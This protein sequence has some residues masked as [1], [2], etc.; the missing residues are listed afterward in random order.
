LG[1]LGIVICIAALII[2]WITSARLHRVSEMLFVK[3]DQA[4]DA[5]RDRISHT[6][7]RVAT[8]TSTTDEITSALRD[9]AQREAG[10]HL[11]VRLRAAE[12]SEMLAA[13]L[14]Q[15]DDWLEVAESSARH[16]QGLLSIDAAAGAP[17]DETLVDQLISTLASMRTQLA[18]AIEAADSLRDRVTD[19]SGG[20]SLDQRI[21]QA[22]P[23]ALRVVTT[24][25][26]IEARLEKLTDGISDAQSRVQELKANTQWWI[27]ISS[28][29]FTLL[30]LLMAAGQVALCWQS[31]NAS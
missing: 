20:E 27:R 19:A 21:E 17:S 5:V 22:L 1:G 18:T 4:L 30:I 26:S 3:M 12:K 6:K 11:A 28:V 16:V 2:L 10:Q 13:R 15:A 8:A 31:W 7:E 24:L 14:Q 9:W 23:L 29:A 25:G